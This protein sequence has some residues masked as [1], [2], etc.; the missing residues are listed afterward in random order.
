MSKILRL[1]TML[2]LG[3]GL[4]GTQSLA[5][6]PSVVLFEDP[7]I[8]AERLPY[9][10]LISDSRGYRILCASQQDEEA[11]IRGLGFT[12]VPSRNLTAVDPEI[13]A[14]NPGI[15]VVQMIQSESMVTVKEGQIEHNL[16]LTLLYRAPESDTN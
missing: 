2:G 4:L 8:G 13:V 16:S 7:G 6:S 11:V 14:A 9:P 1:I 12:T 3:L 15:E 5:Q 10:L